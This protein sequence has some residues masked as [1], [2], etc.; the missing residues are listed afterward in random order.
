[1][2]GISDVSASK[3]GFEP[4]NISETQPRPSDEHPFSDF[5]PKSELEKVDPIKQSHMFTPCCTFGYLRH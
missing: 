4:P 5:T 3:D 1:M 2:F